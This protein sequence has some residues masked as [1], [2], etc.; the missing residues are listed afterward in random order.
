MDRAILENLRSVARTL[1]RELGVLEAGC[2]PSDLTLGECHV[3]IELSQQ[4]EIEKTAHDLA[5]ILCLN[6][7]VVSRTIAQLISKKMITYD[8]DAVDRRRKMLRL[9]KNGFG[10]V[11]AIDHS[12][13]GRVLGAMRLLDK[14]EQAG[15]V[16][17]LTL[18]AEALHRSRLQAEA[19]KAGKVGKVDK[20]GK[21]GK[22]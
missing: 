8:T 13:N 21:G 4:S 14:K 15:V 2:S 12:A 22:K 17:G 5:S 7:S 19:A 9:T 6:K 20:A 10:A 3:L 18:Y 16:T 11:R 1:V